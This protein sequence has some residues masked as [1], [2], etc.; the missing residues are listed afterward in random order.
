MINVNG[1]SFHIFEPKPI[2]HVDEQ[3]V[4]MEMTPWKHSQKAMPSRRGWYR[5]ALIYGLCSMLGNTW[6]VEQ[7]STTLL[8]HTNLM[9]CPGI[10]LLYMKYF[11]HSGTTPRINNF[12]DGRSSANQRSGENELSSQRKDFNKTDPDRKQRC[13][14]VSLTKAKGNAK[15]KTEVYQRHR[16]LQ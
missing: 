14:A 16:R 3:T 11:K 9:G 8:F 6:I 12:F 13:A 4:Y 10:A 15:G 7:A 5:A 1:F 2:Q